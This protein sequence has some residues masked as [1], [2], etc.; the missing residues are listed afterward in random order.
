MQPL[1]GTKQG[2]AERMSYHDVIADFYGEQ[3]ILSVIGDELAKHVA[4]R[5]EDFGQPRGQFFAL[6]R[7]DPS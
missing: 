7:K 5:T 3:A 6:V 4:A 2:A 1:G